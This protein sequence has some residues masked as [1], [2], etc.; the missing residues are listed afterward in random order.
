MKPFYYSKTIIGALVVI[1][2]TLFPQF[3]S[4][5]ELTDI[6]TQLVTLAS[7]LLVI[8]GRITAVKNITI[9]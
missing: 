8:Y 6:I 3:V 9:R 7:A 5:A 4:E 1:I 2:A